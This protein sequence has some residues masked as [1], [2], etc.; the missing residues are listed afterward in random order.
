MLFMSYWMTD[1][2][3][4]GRSVWAHMGV[5]LMKRGVDFDNAMLRGARGSSAGEFG[6]WFWFGQ[7]LEV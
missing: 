4:N 7:L 1:A 3:S 2:A 6:F 5:S